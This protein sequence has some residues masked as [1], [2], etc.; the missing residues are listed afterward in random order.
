[1]AIAAGVVVG[2]AVAFLALYRALH[3]CEQRDAASRQHRYW[4]TGS[5]AAPFV[6]GV[7]AGGLASLRLVFDPYL[8]LALKLVVVAGLMVICVALLE[9]LRWYLHR[10]P[11]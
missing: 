6:G 8:G 7:L 1:M 2:L 4:S 5:P 10:H 9:A 11:N 3:M